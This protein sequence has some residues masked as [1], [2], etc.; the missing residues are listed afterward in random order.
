MRVD[1]VLNVTHVTISISIGLYPKLDLWTA[2]K[3]H[4]VPIY[5]SIVIHYQSKINGRHEDG[6]VKAETCRLFEY[7]IK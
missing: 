7:I 3:L 4:Y 6:F 1:F 5:A 2:N